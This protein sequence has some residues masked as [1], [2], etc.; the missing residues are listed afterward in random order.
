MTF[1]AGPALGLLALAALYVRAVRTLGR[2]GQGV[3]VLQQGFWWA[4]FA[5][6]A[7]AFFSPLDSLAP[8]A[9][10]AHMGQHVLM[11][12]VAVPLMLIGLRNP[13]LFFFLPRSVL[14]PLARRRRLRAA[15]GKLR[16]PMY[17]VPVYTAVLYAW[18]LGPTF[19][20]ALRSQ[21]VHGFQHESF[22]AASALLWWPLVEPNHRRMPGHLWKLP[23]IIGARLPTMF[24]GLAFVVAQTPF[25]T[26]FYGTRTRSGGL[27]PL[28]DQ[29][30]AGS[31]MMITD[32]VILMIVLSVAFLRAASDEDARAPE[33]EAGAQRD[34]AQVEQ[35]A[36]AQAGRHVAEVG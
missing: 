30:L 8:R 14:V 9:V 13:V 26:G 5:C 24:L 2:R 6:L 4:G 28:V 15:F 16:T 31:I 12:D 7:G 21:V 29:Q 34:L 17:A 23:Y 27:S 36:Q 35:E 20:G 33:R 3:P 19:E 25:Y 22:I 10:S 32:V 18:H 1:E 11:A